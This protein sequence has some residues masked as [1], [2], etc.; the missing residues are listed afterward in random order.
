MSRPVIGGVAAAVIA[1][2]T[3]VAYFVTTSSLENRIQ[4]DVELRVAKAQELLVQNA[5]LEMLGLL[6]RAEALA[7]EPGFVQALGGEE[8]DPVGAETVFKKFRAGLSPDERQP[9]ILALTDD[10]GQLIALVSGSTPVVNPIPDTYLKDGAIKYP[11]LKLAIEQRQMTSGIFDYENKGPMKAAVAPVVDRDLDSTLGA[12]IVAYALTSVEAK[13]QQK[14]LGAEVAY[15]FDGKVTATSFGGGGSEDTE[16]QTALGTPLFSGGLAQQALE[17]DTGLSSLEQVE[18]DG[19]TYVATAGRLPRY[20]SQPLPEDFPPVKAGSM[21]LMSMGDA[22]ASVG[23]V[24]MAILL[25]GVGAIVIVLLAI[26]V[27]AKRILGPLDEIELGINDIIN[28][29]LDRSFR[30]VGSDLDGLANALNVMLARLLGRPEPGEEEFDEEGNLIT[31][32][33]MRIAAEGVSPK[34]AEAVALAQEPEDAYLQRLFDE[35]VAARQAAGE[36]GEGVVFETF[37]N[38]LRMNEA[39]LKQKYQCSSVRFKVV[40]DGGKVTLKPVPIA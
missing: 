15:F 32:A 25:L 24:R 28:G 2:L 18:I 39:N 38:K 29:N 8:V 34:D 6:K 27:T 16:K 36:G 23:T 19:E 12:V 20:S 9:D 1:V 22:T 13:E 4:D 40:S 10:Q 14:L 33:Q 3:A 35:Y 37:V 26:L 31:G 30:P 7:R 21:I 5:S 17:S 11:A